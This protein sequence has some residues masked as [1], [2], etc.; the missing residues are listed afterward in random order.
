MSSN[1]SSSSKRARLV[2]LMRELAFEKRKVVLASGRT[3]DFFLDTKQVAL[4]AEGHALLGELMLDALDRLPSKVEAVAG[5]ELGG[6]PLASAVSLTSYL[7]GSGLAA[8][9]VRKQRKDHGTG[10]L[11]EG[12]KSAK[13]G[14]KVAL[15]EDVVTTGGSTL[16]AAETLRQAGLQV[17]GAVVVVDR[18]EGAREAFARA[19]LPYIA[20]LT[21]RDF[22]DD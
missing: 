14:M 1:E 12:D 11:I 19:G 21:R 15:T 2:E 4:T 6:C 8:F 10:K 18:L 17:V 5:V 13:P 9:Y 7:R 3:S 22:M 16:R 20:L